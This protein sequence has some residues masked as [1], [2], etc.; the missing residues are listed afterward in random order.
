MNCGK[1]EEISF[2]ELLVEA[3]LLISTQTFSGGLR[4]G[5]SPVDF[6]LLIHQVLR[7]NSFLFYFVDLV[8]LLRI[9][10]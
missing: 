2:V 1:V 4:Y 10:A 6:A 5:V 7:F 9:L 8:E 3:V